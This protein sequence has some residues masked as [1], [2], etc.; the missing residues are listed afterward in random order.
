[1]ATFT[2]KGNLWIVARGWNVEGTTEQIGLRAPLY[3][4]EEAVERATFELLEDD[5]LVADGDDTFE[6]ILLAI[7]EYIVASIRETQAWF[8][9]LGISGAQ[10]DAIPNFDHIRFFG[11][12]IAF[13]VYDFVYGTAYE[14][15]GPPS[16]YYRAKA[17]FARER[18]DALIAEVLSELPEDTEIVL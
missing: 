7:T 14:A 9:F 17:E 1:M 3:S 6:D 8:A 4:F 11:T 2:Y 18:C 13:F 15:L 12:N 10:D 16:E 5:V